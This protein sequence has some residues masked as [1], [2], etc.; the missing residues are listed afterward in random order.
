[1]KKAPPNEPAVVMQPGWEHLLFLHWRVS[2]ASIQ[3]LLPEGLEV[4]T[5]SGEAWVGLV[6]FT[7]A[8]VCPLWAPRLGNGAL[9]RACY[10][11]HETNVR[12]YVRHKGEAGVWFFSLD[13]ASAPAVVAARLW[14]KLPYFRARMSLDEHD[15]DIHYHSRRLWPHPLPATAA[16]TA[17]PVG[18][19][20]L[21]EAGTLE[22]FLVERYL[23]YSFANGRLL[24]GRVVHSPYVLQ[25][26]DVPA[27]SEN[28]V[29]A[30]G[31]TRPDCEPHAVYA[32]R[33]EVDI[34]GI[35]AA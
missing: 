30:A 20:F 31:V 29:A 16:I 17:R 24:R 12:T 4:D 13:A 15:G 33:V 8:R 32:R 7:M 27:W 18:P 35:E 22:H 1:M 14:Y 6:P 5:F 25:Q 19:S 26:A 2:P 34:F 23:L 3:S 11:F 21:A 28:L 10:A 9:H